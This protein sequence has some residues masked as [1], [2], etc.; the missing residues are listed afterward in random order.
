V[1]GGWGTGDRRRRTE[2]RGRGI[3]FAPG[4]RVSGIKNEGECFCMYF[5]NQYS[6]G[7]KLEQVL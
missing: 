1:D 4:V 7:L 3:R 6:T 5:Q 2:D